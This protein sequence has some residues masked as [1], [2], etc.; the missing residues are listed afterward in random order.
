MTTTQITQLAS[1]IVANTLMNGGTTT[2]IEGISPNSGYMVSTYKDSELTVN[3]SGV[4]K[5]LPYLISSVEW[6]IMKYKDILQHEGMYLGTWISDDKIYIDIST[7]VQTK[8]KANQLA[9]DND[10]LAYWSLDE[11]KEYSTLTFDDFYKYEYH[12]YAPE[13]N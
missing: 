4:K 2:N 5:N 7:C 10:Q 1:M 3:L 12:K 9:I 11:S 13:L 6:F 8:T